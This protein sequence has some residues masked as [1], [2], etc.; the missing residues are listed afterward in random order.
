MSTLLDLIMKF[1]WNSFLSLVLILEKFNIYNK[2][3]FNI[4]LILILLIIWIIFNNL[5][6]SMSGVH[7]FLQGVHTKYN[8]YSSIVLAKWD[9]LKKSELVKTIQE[10]DIKKVIKK[11]INNLSFSELYK[12]FYN[13]FYFCLFFIFRNNCFI[14]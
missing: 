11:E 1:I 12:I 13:K 3:T 5:K 10:F 4:I 9:K 8:F 6:F 7:F 2:M 14:I